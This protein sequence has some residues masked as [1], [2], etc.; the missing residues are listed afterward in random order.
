MN[1]TTEDAMTE[2]ATTVAAPPAQTSRQWWAAVRGDPARLNAW[3]LDQLRGEA[4]AAARIRALRDQ[5][6][7]PVT[8][9]SAAQGQH[10]TSQGA[11]ADH[12]HAARV[13][14][15]IAEQ[16]E[17]HA[18][19]VADLLRARGV[20]PVVVEKP[21]RYWQA[22]HLDEI[23]DLETGCAVGAWAERMRLE[24]ID[25]IAAAGDHGADIDDIADIVA[26]FQRI[27]PEER[28]H[29]RAFS[30]LAG[31]V[32]LHATRDA[33]ELGRRALGLHP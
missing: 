21:A 7:V 8:H 22:C 4:T 10:A 28:F 26:V 18:S 19:W 2:Q 17:R 9:A 20:D 32:A 14:T 11:A 15:V 16:E 33:H 29:E 25:V 31:A 3:L 23:A 1:A 6:A 13:L 12:N 30:D 5:F 24:R 27:L